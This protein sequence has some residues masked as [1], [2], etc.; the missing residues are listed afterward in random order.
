[1]FFGRKGGAHLSLFAL[2]LLVSTVARAEN[3]SV[4][5][6][7]SENAF[8]F[9]IGATRVIYNHNAS[10]AS[11]WIKNEHQYPVI[12]Q[13]QVLNDD[14]KSKAP[15][16]I[17]PPVLRVDGDMQTRLR[18][19]P[20]HSPSN[21]NTEELYWICIKGLPPKG[22]TNDITNISQLNI[23]VITNSCIKLISRPSK[24]NSTIKDAVQ[25][26]EFEVRGGELVIHNNSPMYINISN[27]AIN[28]KK[29]KIPNGYIKPYNKES[30]NVRPKKGDEIQLSI[31]DD[32]GAEIIRSVTL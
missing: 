18:I 28:N 7:V 13:A 6:I 32:Y 3:A 15:F 29:I 1:M 4:K 21:R 17:T 5:Q 23:N 16:I 22:E 20:K 11:F 2:T 30:V 25:M 10:A 31:L 26:L 9:K 12:V 14:K 27:A 8:G 19:I 24:I